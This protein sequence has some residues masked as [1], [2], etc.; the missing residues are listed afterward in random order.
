[1]RF[2]CRLTLTALK[3][4]TYGIMHL[5]VAIIVAYV[6]TGNWAV[7]LGIGLIEPMVQTVFYTFHENVWN[8]IG[9]RSAKRDTRSTLQVSSSYQSYHPA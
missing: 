8:R 3:P 7:A 6:L 2:R 5:A 9:Q 1:M 4:L